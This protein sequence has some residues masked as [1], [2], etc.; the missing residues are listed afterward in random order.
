MPRIGKIP[1]N[2]PIRWDRE[3]PNRAIEAINE[4][5]LKNQFNV[6]RIEAD[7]TGASTGSGGGEIAA[8]AWQK[9]FLMMGA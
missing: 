8:E 9:I 3:N 4:N 5:F 7:L 6:S 1:Q 2:Y